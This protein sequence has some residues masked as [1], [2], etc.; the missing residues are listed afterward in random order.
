MCTEAA[1]AQ[2]V[3]TDEA[4]QTIGVPSEE[5]TMEN[6]NL[7]TTKEL[8]VYY[9]SNG[10]TTNNGTPSIISKDGITNESNTRAS[11]QK[12][13]L[14]AVDVS[15]RCPTAKQSALRLYPL[16]FL[17]DFTGVVLDNEIGKLLEYFHLIKHPNYKTYWGYS[18]GNEIGRLAQGM[19]GR[20]TGTDTLQI[21]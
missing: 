18:F 4:E 10:T 16:Q 12:K 7:I 5:T 6:D 21:H 9:S 19:P 11:R 3:V 13:L 15:D 20:N 2:R 8:E 14:S 1:Q 17:E